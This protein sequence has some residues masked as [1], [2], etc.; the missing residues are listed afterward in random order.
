MC[1]RGGSG[2]YVLLTVQVPVVGCA[3]CGAGCSCMCV[4]RC[5]GLQCVCWDSACTWLYGRSRGRGSFT[6]RQGPYLTS[7]SSLSLSVGTPELLRPPHLFA[8]T[9]RSHDR[10]L[11]ASPR[12]AGEGGERSVLCACAVCCVLCA[13]YCARHAGEGAY[14]TVCCVSRFTSARRWESVAC[15][16]VCCMLC[17]VYWC[18]LCALC[19]MVCEIK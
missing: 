19:V 13:V 10:S 2:D 6:S 1:E 15:A 14:C 3:R 8:H 4:V 18:V 11:P 9:F 17:A 7:P 12:H 16:A 5:S